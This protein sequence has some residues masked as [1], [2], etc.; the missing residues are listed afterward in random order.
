MISDMSDHIQGTVAAGWEGVRD[1]FKANFAAD[2]PDG[3]VGAGV[4]IYHHGELVVDLTGGT[5]DAEGSRPYDADAL[6]L[7]FSTTK[8]ITAIAV[9]ICADRGLIDYNATVASYWPE[10]AAHD[11]DTVTVAQLLSHQA[12]LITVGGPPLS[13]AEALDLPTITSR[14]ADTSPLWPLGDGHGYHALTY[15]WLA[16]ELVRRVDPA[17]RTLGQ[18]V[19]EE[20]VAPVGGGAEFFIGLP[21]SHEPRVSPLIGAPLNAKNE[22]PQI[23]AML[24]M[25]LGPDSMGGKALFLGGAFAA[26]GTFNRRDVHAAEIGAANGITNAR[27]LARIYA[28]TIGEVDGVRLVSS[29]V[30]DRARVTITPKGEGD[31][32]LIMP[33]TFG[34]GFMTHG[35]FTPYTGPGCFGHAGAGGSVAFA[36]PETG[37]AFGYAMNKMASNLAGDVRAANLMAAAKA[38]AG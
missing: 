24:E 18:F 4:A 15:G 10:F 22:D 23:Q 13:L 32:C 17:G 38:V 16:G 7:V 9:A 25:F 5:F 6:Q 3:D 37:L 14:L 28:A 26:E 35:D 33:T 34:L 31:K 21:E 27:S 12:G 8:G 29:D 20:I 2:N 1:A 19:A 36:Q 11:K 30:I